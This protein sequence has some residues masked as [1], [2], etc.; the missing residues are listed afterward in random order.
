MVLKGGY[1][2]LRKDK[3]SGKRRKQK[4]GRASKKKVRIKTQGEVRDNNQEKKEKGNLKRIG[5]WRNGC[6]QNPLA[7][8]EFNS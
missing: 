7:A 4:E 1:T 3:F 5:H 2:L 8:W 6:V